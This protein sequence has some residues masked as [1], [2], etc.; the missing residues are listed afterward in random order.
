VR[1]FEQT[2]IAEVS[3][4]YVE[5]ESRVEANCR[6]LGRLRMWLENLAEEPTNGK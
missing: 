1:H 4:V 2:R 5:K 6:A 3:Y